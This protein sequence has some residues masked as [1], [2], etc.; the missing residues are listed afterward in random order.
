MELKRKTINHSIIQED[1]FVIK[2]T[3]NND[4]TA[5]I[6]FKDSPTNNCQLGC[7]ADAC[8][9]SL[10]TT[11]DIKDILIEVNNEY[12]LRNILLLDINQEYKD[13]I[14][15]LFDPIC[16]K[17]LEYDYISSNESPMTLLLCYINF[18]KI[19]I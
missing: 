5:N 18:D 1:C 11:N 9:F 13:T 15:K 14:I 19:A 16:D 4:A 7:V 10:L 17:I 2:V 8:V 6:I 3:F 12:I